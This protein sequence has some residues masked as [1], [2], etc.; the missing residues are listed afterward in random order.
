M[1]RIAIFT[2]VFVFILL[3]TKIANQVPPPPLPGAAFSLMSQRVVECS[4]TDIT[5]LNNHQTETH[6]DKDSSWPPCS[7]FHKDEVLDFFLSRGAKTKFLSDEK[8]VWW[9]KAL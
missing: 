4:P 8:T 9:R 5:L 2:A 7:A 6:L 3:L 1:K